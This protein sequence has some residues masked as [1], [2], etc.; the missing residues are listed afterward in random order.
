M[1]GFVKSFIGN[2]ENVIHWVMQIF[3]MLE[4]FII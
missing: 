1:Y 2:L 3:Q 4:H